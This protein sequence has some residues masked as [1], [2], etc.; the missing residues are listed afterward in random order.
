[1]LGGSS[2]PSKLAALAAARRKKGEE[3]QQ[4]GQQVNADTERAINLLNRLGSRKDEPTASQDVQILQRAATATATATTATAS[5]ATSE[6]REKA[7]GGL[8]SELE[9]E[10]ASLPDSSDQAVEETR[11]EVLRGSP[12]PFAI[13]LVGAIQDQGQGVSRPIE[14]KPDP[15]NVVFSMPTVGLRNSEAPDPF[16]SPSPDDVVLTAQGKGSSLQ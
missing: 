11:V 6:I 12:S 10:H 3:K 2:K 16:S 4:S 8:R 13:A 7:S 1:L 15:S 14:R 9:T 5:R